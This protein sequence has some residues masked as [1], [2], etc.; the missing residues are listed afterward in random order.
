M[1]VYLLFYLLNIFRDVFLFLEVAHHQL[2]TDS[3]SLSRKVRNRCQHENTFPI[4]Y[5]NDFFNIIVQNN[6]TCLHNLQAQH[7]Y[8]LIITKKEITSIDNCTSEYNKTCNRNKQF[9]NN[10]SH[11]PPWLPMFSIANGMQNTSK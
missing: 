4:C 7:L 3:Y 5:S 1:G 11:S 9:T 6:F 10:I 2:G 8:L